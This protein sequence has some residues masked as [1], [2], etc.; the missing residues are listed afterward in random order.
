MFQTA[1]LFQLPTEIIKVDKAESPL[2]HS[3]LLSWDARISRPRVS[4]EVA[5]R[6]MIFRYFPA[7]KLEQ[8]TNK[9]SPEKGTTLIW[10]TA[11]NVYVLPIKYLNYFSVLII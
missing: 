10:K 6:Q 4:L 1:S 3:F 2:S 5:H 9:I 7:N 8:E 11:K